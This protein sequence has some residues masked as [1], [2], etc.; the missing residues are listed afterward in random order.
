MGDAFVGSRAR[1]WHILGGLGWFAGLA[2]G[3]GRLGGVAVDLK[4]PQL[5]KTLRLGTL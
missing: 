1:P 2:T 4:Q 3:S 5:K